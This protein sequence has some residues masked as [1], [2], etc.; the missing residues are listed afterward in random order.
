MQKFGF[1]VELI[2][3]FVEGLVPIDRLEETFGARF[4]YRESDYAIVSESHGRRRG[5]AEKREFHLGDRLRVRAE[6][7]DSFR[8]RVEFSVLN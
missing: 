5:A 7:I 4:R 8:N 3:V 6:R 2:E 1:F